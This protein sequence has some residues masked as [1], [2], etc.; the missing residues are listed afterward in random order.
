M[1]RRHLQTAVL[2][3]LGLVAAL[4]IHFIPVSEETPEAGPAAIPSNVDATESPSPGGFVV[5]PSSRPGP[6]T[7]IAPTPQPAVSISTTPDTSRAHETVE[8]EGLRIDSNSRRAITISW[9]PAPG[10]Q[11]YAIL[12]NGGIVGYETSEYAIILWETARM[13]VGVAAETDAGLGRAAT[14]DIER[15]A[16]PPTPAPT[17][18]ASPTPTPTLPA[19]TASVSPSGMIPEPPVQSTPTVTVSPTPTAEPPVESPEPT[20]DPGEEETSDEL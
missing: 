3:A 15:P 9:D 11:R 2:L 7:G 12:S 17:S 20:P 16:A 5:E 14:V 6:P 19:P 1:K 10:A 4:T 8:V 18:A 13:R